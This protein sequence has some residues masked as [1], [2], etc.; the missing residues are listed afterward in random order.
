MKLGVTEYSPA[1]WRLFID[2]FNFSDSI[3]EV[4]LVAWLS[5]LGVDKNFLG[6]YRADNYKGIL[7]NMLGNLRLLGIN[8]SIIF[9]TA[10]WII[11]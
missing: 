7:N 4:E 2:S 1:D 11:F 8:M 5:F 10:T 3:N 9:S 6:N